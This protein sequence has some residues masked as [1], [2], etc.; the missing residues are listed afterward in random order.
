MVVPA[1]KIVPP[2]TSSEFASMEMPPACDSSAATTGYVKTSVR[3][4]VAVLD[5]QPANRSP[6]MPGPPN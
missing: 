3:V 1:A 2:M 5:D 6:D 4:L